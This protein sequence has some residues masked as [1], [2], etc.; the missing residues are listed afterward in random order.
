M[1]GVLLAIICAGLPGL[2]TRSVLTDGFVTKTT[3][4]TAY[5]VNVDGGSDSAPCTDPAAP[6]ATLSGVFTKFPNSIRN[7]QTISI[8]PGT[9]T[10]S[11]SLDNLDV[12]A[13]ITITGD[14][15]K[16]ATPATGGPD[17]GLT[18]VTL[19][20]PTILTDSA[21][22]WTANDLIGTFITIGSATRVV[23]T[24]TSTTLTLASPFAS[25]PTVGN[26]YSLKV[27]SVIF[28]SSSVG[29]PTLSIR[30]AGNNNLTT[31]FSFTG[32]DIVNTG[33][34][35]QPCVVALS[36]QQ[37]LLTNSR[38][39]ATSGTGASA[40]S[41]RGGGILSLSGSAAIGAGSGVSVTVGSTTGSSSS[42]A[43]I[44]PAN[45][46]IHG[47][48]NNG[49][50]ITT[51]SGFSLSSASSWTAQTA[52]SSAFFGA[53]TYN[54]SMARSVSGS[55][56]LVVRCITAGAPGIIQQQTNPIISSF[57]HERLYIDNCTTGI[58]MSAGSL[59]SVNI[60][61]ELTC[62]NTGT[63]IKAY[64]GARIKLPSTLAMQDGGTD[65]SIDGVT[66]TVTQLNAASPTWLPTTFTPQG[67][68]VWK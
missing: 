47:T 32:V 40:I 37:F 66:Y 67:S 54:G 59:T 27:P 29:T 4:T 64:N 60:A 6:C 53:I 58:D 16:N 5:Y 11:I 19:G 65:I 15:L 2:P 44:S 23:A 35:G 62:I 51:S 14:A 13:N 41:Y 48:A 56:V 28:T 68:R 43:T 52:G 55:G 8:A 3:A 30:L 21:Q 61:S 24:N 36:T 46:L 25:N 22:A 42:L 34:S 18:A 50:S 39:R 38:C 20:N 1:S 49:L 57:T 10:D 9:Y 63:C 31:S 33:S 12:M 7:A 26:E 45:S 17:G